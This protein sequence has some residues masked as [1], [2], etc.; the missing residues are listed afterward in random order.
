[1][2]HVCQCVCVCVCPIMVCEKKCVRNHMDGCKVGGCVRSM[3]DV[4][5]LRV[6]VWVSGWVRA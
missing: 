2:C 3:C 1:M 4:R 5:A 6:S